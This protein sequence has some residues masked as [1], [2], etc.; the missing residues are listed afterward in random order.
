MHLMQANL[1]LNLTQN[2]L[3]GT[4]PALFCGLGQTQNWLYRDF[5]CDAVLCRPGTFSETGHATLHSACRACKDSAYLGQTS[6]QDVDFV[7]GDWNGDGVLSPREILRVLFLDLIGRFWGADYQRWENMNV[8]ACKLK[9]V[10]C[11]SDGTVSGI[12]L[13]HAVLC[14]NSEGKQ[15]PVQY[16]K[17]LPSELGLLSSLEHLHFQ[18]QSF[19]F[20][21]IPS[22]I[23][24]LAKL[25]TL[26][27]S[28]AD[29]LTGILHSN[30]GKLTS[31]KTLK[32]TNSQ[33]G[34]SIPSQV[35]A[36]P[37]LGK[38]NLNNNWLTGT[39]PTSIQ[40]MR[41]VDEFFIS[42]NYLNGTIPTEVGKMKSLT[43]LEA[44]LNQLTGT[45]PSEFGNNLEL[46]RLGTLVH[47]KSL[48]ILTLCC[49]HL[50]K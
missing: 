45:I 7:H 9:G 14:G 22:E 6:C 4:I 24:N 11:H 26:D 13:N 29:A 20:G 16:C 5:G 43:N 8:P 42:M 2:R 35:L 37:N 18:G 41:Y 49:R 15:G 10:T 33:L 3:T 44:Y 27:L 17:G 38:I 12:N 40:R 36:L 47:R 30:L 50:P 32:I 28:N 46:K 1:R 31:L 25:Q 19:L 34:G 48:Y 39:L 21:S 23:G